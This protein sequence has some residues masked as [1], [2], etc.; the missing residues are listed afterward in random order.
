MS[1]PSAE[2]H[3]PP[4]V[5]HAHT[6]EWYRYN[7][8]WTAIRKDWRHFCRVHGAESQFER[9]MIAL[10][11]RSLWALAAYRFGRWTYSQ[12]S[13]I[14][15]LPFKLMYHVLYLW[16]QYVSK[17][18]IDVNADLG[19][20]VFLSPVGLLFI[21]PDVRIG[22]GSFIHGQNTVGVG[23]RPGARG[24][25][26]LGDRVHVGPG[27]TLVGPILVPDDTVIGPNSVVTRTLP[28]AGGWLGCPA[29]PYGGAVT[30]LIPSWAGGW[31]RY[32]PDR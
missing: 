20:D 11:S 30:D 16:G 4:A 15:S 1:E 3:Y 25:P 19:E 6:H 28:S 8:G 24:L 14:L 10:S 2:P 31:R 12:R 18:A 5:P 7:A 29:K 26:M 9:L 32:G 13:G 27:A 23:G 22:P 21:G 17:V